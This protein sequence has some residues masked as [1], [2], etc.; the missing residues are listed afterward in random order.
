MSFQNIIRIAFWGPLVQAKHVDFFKIS[1]KIQYFFLIQYN[2]GTRTLIWYMKFMDRLVK[3]HGYLTQNTV[4]STKLTYSAVYQ[5]FFDELFHG[6][7]NFYYPNT[8]L[9]VLWYLEIKCNALQLI[10]FSKKD[11][12]PIGRA[13]N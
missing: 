7:Q 8:S 9:Q 3:N 13:K 6:W 12:C 5:S 11:I 10:F 4:S 2:V 1:K